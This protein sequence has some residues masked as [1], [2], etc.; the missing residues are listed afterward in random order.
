MRRA[1]SVSIGGKLI[2]SG[3]PTLLNAHQYLSFPPLHYIPSVH[4]LFHITLYASTSY[5][6]SVRLEPLGVRLPVAFL[7]F[8]G[9]LAAVAHKL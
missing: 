5:H 3:M 4:S 7:V 2:L 9:P 8:G 1:Y 6:G